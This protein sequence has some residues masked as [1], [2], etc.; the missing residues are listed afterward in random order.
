ML[1]AFIFS[2]SKFYRM[3]FIIFAIYIVKIAFYEQIN[4]L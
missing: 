4:K 2:F 1:N 3:K